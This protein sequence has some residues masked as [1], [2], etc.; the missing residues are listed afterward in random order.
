MVTRVVYDADRPWSPDAKLG[1]Y[2]E[3]IDVF[4]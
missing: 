2:W 4:H 1:L 3:V